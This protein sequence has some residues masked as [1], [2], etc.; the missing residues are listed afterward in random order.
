MGSVASRAAQYR[1]KTGRATSVP[2]KKAKQPSSAANPD[3]TVQ[4]LNRG[5]LKGPTVNDKD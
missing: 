2:Y 1:T 5:I 4:S 3:S